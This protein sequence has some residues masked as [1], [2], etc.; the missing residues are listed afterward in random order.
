M[1]KFALVADFSKSEVRKAVKAFQASVKPIE[2]VD[3]FEK[4]EQLDSSIISQKK[5]QGI[6]VFGGDG[7]ILSTARQLDAPIP[8]VGVNF[9]KVGFLTEVSISE[10]PQCM[11]KIVS[12][13]F[14]VQKRIMLHFEII[15][16]GEVVNETVALN[17][18]VI[19][20]VASRLICCQIKVNDEEMC[21]YGGD[22][23]IISTPVGST[24]YSMSA[25]GPV[26][27]PGMSAMIITP[28][29]P[30]TLTMRPVII[31]SDNT[32]EVC[33]Y[34]PYPGGCI[35][36]ADGQIYFDLNENDIIRVKQAERSF[37]I[38]KTGNRNFF[39]ILKEKFSWGGKKY[40]MQP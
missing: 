32:I 7:F 1:E 30:H 31:P 21:T 5:I 25:G 35:F 6:I 28:I 40:L 4:P 9:G 11:S 16:D 3:C 10:L 24:A 27:T 15:R 14:T 22:G 34:P 23:V 8:V 2:L 17:D 29:C 13:E 39:D 36:T 33:F 18:G 26:L 20:N 12:G 38:L 37:H 19:K